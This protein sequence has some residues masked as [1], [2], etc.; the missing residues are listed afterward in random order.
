MYYALAVPLPLSVHTTI[1][2]PRR[3][4]PAAC[5]ATPNL[6]AHTSWQGILVASRTVLSALHHPSVDILDSSPAA[7]PTDATNSCQIAHPL[8][9]R[10]LRIS[11]VWQSTAIRNRSIPHPQTARQSDTEYLECCLENCRTRCSLRNARC[12][13]SAPRN[14]PNADP[15]P[16]LRYSIRLN[17]ST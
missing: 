6:P 2:F 13:I 3:C 17:R 16:C 9:P 10:Q 8:H 12:C 14:S 15:V 5:S 4:T 11:H 1:L 7:L